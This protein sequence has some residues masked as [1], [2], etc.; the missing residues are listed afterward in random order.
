MR[1][2][3]P[4]PA[5][6]YTDLSDLDFGHDDLDELDVPSPLRSPPKALGRAVSGV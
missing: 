6:R 2:Y 4:L 5:P 3:R 1:A